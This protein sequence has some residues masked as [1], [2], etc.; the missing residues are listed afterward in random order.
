MP[1]LS[2]KLKVPKP[3]INVALV[4]HNRKPININNP[5]NSGVVRNRLLP[6]LLL[7]VDNDNPLVLELPRDRLLPESAERVE[8]SLVLDVGEV[9][10]LERTGALEAVLELPALLD[11]L[12]DLAAREEAATL[13]VVELVHHALEAVLHYVR[14]F[15]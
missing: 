12:G 1:S 14:H 6:L 2:T 13:E 5:D 9:V 15:F 11:N 4:A 8:L 7:L 3:E 10:L